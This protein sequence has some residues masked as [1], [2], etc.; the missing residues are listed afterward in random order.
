[1][2]VGNSLPFN[3]QFFSTYWYPYIAENGTLQQYPVCVTSPYTSPFQTPVTS[4]G[5]SPYGSPVQT[6]VAS[7]R[8]SPNVT[9]VQ[10]PF[11]TP[12]YGPNY[13][14][15]QNVVTP[16]FNS[17]LL[18]PVDPY[19]TQMGAFTLPPAAINQGIHPVPPPLEVQQTLVTVPLQGNN[20]LWGSNPQSNVSSSWA[21]PF[22]NFSTEQNVTVTQVD[23]LQI[24]AFEI[25]YE[26]EVT[27]HNATE[28]EATV[29]TFQNEINQAVKKFLGQ[30][31][32]D[33]QLHVNEQGKSTTLCWEVDRATCDF[34][35]LQKK[36]QTKHFKEKLICELA[37]VGNGVLNKHL[38][39]SKQL[40]II[41]H[42][43]KCFNMTKHALESFNKSKDKLLEMNPDDLFDEENTEHLFDVC[44]AKKGRA[45]RGQNVLGGHFRGEDVPKI[46]QVLQIVEEEIGTIKRATMI[47]SMKGRSQYKGWSIYIETPSVD[48]V[49]RII[50]KAYEKGIFERRS[51]EEKKKELFIAVDKYDYRRLN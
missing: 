39:S 32:L 29:N 49:E 5:N 7:P 3:N 38:H 19:H 13:P 44:K 12:G 23:P 2:T 21:A 31:Q 25:F 1:M 46:T 9:P 15:Q 26:L 22:P 18:P 24:S 41:Y 6:P 51:K 10:T 37:L 4:P 40:S 27:K 14:L 36:I 8:H 17:T 47:P 34:E 43:Y 28:F 11:Q 30:P 33:I 42:G 35:A 48:H 20:Q 45:L 16:L 50:E